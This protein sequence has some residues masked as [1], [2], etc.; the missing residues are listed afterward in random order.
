TSR[1]SPPSCGS[2]FVAQ[3]E[4]APLDQGHDLHENG[5]ASGRKHLYRFLHAQPPFGRF[6]KSEIRLSDL[7]CGCEKR[8]HCRRHRHAVR[9]LT[10]KQIQGSTPNE[11]SPPSQTL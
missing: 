5:V 11:S 9:Q 8:E 4:L 6:S 10:S 3:D 1:S 2:V 7:S